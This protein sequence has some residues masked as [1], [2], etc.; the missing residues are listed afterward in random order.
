MKFIN[1]YK[2]ISTNKIQDMKTYANLGKKNSTFYM[3]MLFLI[4]VRHSKR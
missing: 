2:I 3:L 1:E 4:Y